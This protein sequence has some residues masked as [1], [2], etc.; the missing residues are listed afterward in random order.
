MQQLQN[1]VIV[2]CMVSP[3]EI[4]RHA[5]VGALVGSAERLADELRLL[6]GTKV[7]QR[8]MELRQTFSDIARELIPDEATENIRRLSLES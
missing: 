8:V 6:N 4:G 2:Q 7:R 1:C 5:V 3:S